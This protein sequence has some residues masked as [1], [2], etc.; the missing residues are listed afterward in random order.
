MHPEI[1]ISSA[2]DPALRYCEAIT[3]AG[4]IPTAQYCPPATAVEVYDALVLTGGGDI[5]PDFF[6]LG[7]LGVSTFLDCARDRAELALT[8]AFLQAGKPI[9][10]ICR[11]AQLLNIALGGTLTQDIPAPRRST[12]RAPVGRAAHGVTSTPGSFLAELYGTECRVNSLHHQALRR[13][14]AGIVPCQWAEDGIVE[15]Y[16][17]PGQPVWAV[18]WHPELLCNPR[19]RPEGVVDG[20]LLFDWWLRQ[21]RSQ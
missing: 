18:Q 19:Y 15:G 14:G 2:N 3:A 1:L 20:Q 16:C 10:A 12:H 4:G 9:L 5:H 17:L 13:L 6:A 21:C 11:G 8:A 7:D